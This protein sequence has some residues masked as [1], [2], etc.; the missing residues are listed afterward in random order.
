[1]IVANGPE[2]RR[3]EPGD[4]LTFGRLGELVVGADNRSL[5]RVLGCFASDGDRWFVQNLG[6]FTTIVV[7]D[8]SGGSRVE[9]DP[10]EQAAIGCEEFAVRFAA[11]G[12]HYEL[13][14]RLLRP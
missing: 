12:E 9:I 10:G 13:V 4:T 5:H 14:G 1:M 2:S 3:T 8:R 6:R 7:T 11:G